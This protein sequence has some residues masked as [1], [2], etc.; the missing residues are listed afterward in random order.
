MPREYCRDEHWANFHCV[1]PVMRRRRSRT[2]GRDRLAS[3]CCAA[4]EVRQEVSCRSTS[5]LAGSAREIGDR[6]VSGECPA[7]IEKEPSPVDSRLIASARAYCRFASYA[8]M[9]RGWR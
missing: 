5:R 6:E 7:D 3:R 4:D 8:L 9:G 1:A 2:P